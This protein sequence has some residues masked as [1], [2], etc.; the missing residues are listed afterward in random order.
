[1]PV[2][3]GQS[4]NAI[5][6]ARRLAS[7]RLLPQDDERIT[8]ARQIR[9]L[10]GQGRTFAACAQAIGV[11]T[12]RVQEFAN[13]QVYDAIVTHLE[14]L[15]AGPD[16]SSR[17]EPRPDGRSRLSRLVP[18]ALDRLERCLAEG[19]APDG[20]YRESRAADR[21]MD[22]VLAAAGL[23][24]PETAERP[25][26]VISTLVIQSLTQQILADDAIGARRQ[27]I[28]RA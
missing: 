12:K 26:I 6:L 14:R 9:S 27:D 1:M 5:A 2:Q 24:E 19:I 8:F 4:P 23:L 25:T 20:S 11:P 22:T 17:A 18:R 15:E 10:R 13:G 28:H 21:A 3:P 16:A 7:G